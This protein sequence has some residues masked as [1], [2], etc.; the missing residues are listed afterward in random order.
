MYP[1]GYSIDS[2]ENDNIDIHV[3]LENNEVYFAT[4]FT[5]KNIEYLMSK[6]F[7]SCFWADDMIIVHNLGK[8]TIK[9]SIKKIISDGYLNASF[10]KIGDIKSVYA[11]KTSFDD[12]SDKSENIKI[13]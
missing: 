1:S 10:S 5:L 7:D 13:V 4:L 6:N 12:F 2:V 11:N 3:I 8:K 9:E